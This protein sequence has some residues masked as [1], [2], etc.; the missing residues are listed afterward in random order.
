MAETYTC[1][2]LLMQMV[3]RNGTDILLSVGQPPQMRISKRLVSLEYDKLTPERAKELT[4][5]VMSE[6][7][8]K[9]PASILL[10]VIR[11]SFSEA[12][13]T[14]YILIPAVM[15]YCLSNRKL[16]GK[17]PNPEIL[18]SFQVR[19]VIMALPFWPLEVI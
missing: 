10:P 18:L 14:V 15:V 16:E 1:K 17:T 2:D 3:Q 8:Q 12:R 13:Q 6:S 7:Q 5:Q 11:R 4:Y 9:K 19:W